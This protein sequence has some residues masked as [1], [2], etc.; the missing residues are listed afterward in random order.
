MG[1]RNFL[2]QR[3]A[4][5]RMSLDDE[6]YDLLETPAGR[7]T[8]LE[9]L[10]GECEKSSL[11]YLLEGVLE[12][13]GDIVECGVYR[14]ASLRRIAKTAKDRTPEKTVFG[15]DSFEGFPEDGV[16]DADSSAARSVNRLAG[17]FRDAFD[18]P[19]RL[20]RFGTAFDLNLELRKGY[21]EHTLPG[22]VEREFCFIHIDCDTY[23][24]HIEV[25]DALYDRLVPGGCIV[26]DDYNDDAWPG[27]TK[28][29]D[30]FFADRPGTVELCTERSEPAWFV[31]KQ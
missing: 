26:F 1:L 20:E 13:P 22:I 28:A 16:T 9:T 4:A 17:K 6:F 12:L 5:K 30:E 24:G 29:T 23:A 3:R 18:V 14:G 10:S 31:T 15:L 21:F 7:E 27:A 11:I 25:L 19:Q 8:F 2:R